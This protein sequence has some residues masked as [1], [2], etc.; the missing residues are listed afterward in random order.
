[1]TKNEILAFLKE[2]KQE[3]KDKFGATR[4]GLAGSYARGEANED[5]DIDIIVDL[6]SNNRF[7]SFFYLQYFLQDALGKRIDLATDSS[8]KPLVRQSVNRDILYV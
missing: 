3:I 4:I 5:S 6:H 2:H 7:R 8:L 1:M